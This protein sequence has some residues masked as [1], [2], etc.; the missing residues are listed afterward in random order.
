MLGF[1]R[2]RDSSPWSATDLPDRGLFC[3]A[4]L[5][6][7]AAEPGHRLLC[8]MSFELLLVFFV[9]Q[10]ELLR[11]GSDIQACRG[12]QITTALSL[13]QPAPG[14]IAQGLFASEWDLRHRHRLRL[15]IEFS[16]SV[17]NQLGSASTHWNS[18]WW[19]IGRG[20]WRWHLGLVGLALQA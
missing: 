19:L 4:C 1:L 18:R 12:R 7:P 2:A 8:C 5:T 13:G 9:I 15:P 17:P 20:R 11:L 14:L 6:P 3:T 10:A 16:H